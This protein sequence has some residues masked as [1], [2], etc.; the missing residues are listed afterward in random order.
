MLSLAERHFCSSH[1]DSS[2]LPTGSEVLAH[3]GGIGCIGGISERWRRDRSCCQLFQES[4]AVRCEK[5]CC[6]SGAGGVA[7]VSCAASRWRS[8]AS[9]GRMRRGH[10]APKVAAMPAA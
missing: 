2:L 5:T 9:S 7:E 3:G 10:W 8:S 4:G 6:S 1:V